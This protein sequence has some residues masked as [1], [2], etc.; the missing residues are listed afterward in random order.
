V[1]AV[2][3]HR[4]L[5]QDGDVF[6]NVLPASSV[7]ATPTEV[8]FD[9]AVDSGPPPPPPP[10]PPPTTT[11]TTTTPTVPPITIPTVT[12]PTIPQDRTPPFLK[13][14]YARRADR[15]GRY[16]IRIAATGEAAAGTVTLR[17][18]RGSRRTLATGSLGTAGIRP[19]ART[20]RLKS[21]DLRLLKRKRRLRVTVAVSL[22]DLSG[23]TARGHRTFTLRLKR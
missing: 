22:R 8:P 20:L 12:T 6:V 3:T 17:L 11:T 18:A 23:N 10:P 13:V 5:N 15:R 16:T 7:P 14:T 19:F 9:D 2:W 1:F 21:K 4:L